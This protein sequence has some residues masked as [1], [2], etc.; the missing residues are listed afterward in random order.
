MVY[1]F[2]SMMAVEHKVSQHGLNSS[3]SILRKGARVQSL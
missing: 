2:F 3:A 1:F